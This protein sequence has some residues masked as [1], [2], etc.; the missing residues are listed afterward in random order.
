MAKG[1]TKGT[2][3]RLQR[4]QD[5]CRLAEIEER[6]A[7]QLSLIRHLA[8]RRGRD[9]SHAESLLWTLR[10]AHGALIAQRQANMTGTRADDDAPPSSTSGQP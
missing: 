1:T 4:A 5:A 9:T 3:A 7:Q 2:Y 8:T 10:Q 6:I